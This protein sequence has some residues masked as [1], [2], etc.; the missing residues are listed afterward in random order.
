MPRVARRKV[1]LRS[2]MEPKSNPN[3][4]PILV[5]SSQAPVIPTTGATEGKHAPEPKHPNRAHG[6]RRSGG[7]D[8]LIAESLEMEAEQAR[9]N[10]NI[11]KS[12]REQIQE[13]YERMQGIESESANKKQVAQEDNTEEET[14]NETLDT[15]G[16]ELSQEETEEVVPDESSKGEELQP[17]E[18]N[19][20]YQ[21]YLKSEQRIKDTQ[22]RM[23]EATTESANY[24][25]LV[26]EI[27]TKTDLGKL[28]NPELS[29]KTETKS[30][31][32]PPPSVELMINDNEKF[33]D[34]AV[35]H[36]A[37]NP[38]LAKALVEKVIP[39]VGPKISQQ[40]AAEQLERKFKEDYKNI[41]GG[42][43][44]YIPNMNNLMLLEQKSNPHAT[45]WDLYE[46]TKP[47]F[48][49][50]VGF[51]PRPKPER[52]TV[53]LE[54]PSKRTEVEPSK[55]DTL[56]QQIVMGDAKYEKES[57]RD[58]MKFRRKMLNDKTMGY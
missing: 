18:N 32:I 56:D 10:P 34:Q 28:L 22:N 7:K 15:S 6:P 50:K 21:E 33:W 36:I 38:K 54:S 4:E 53:P 9:N 44:F 12:Q 45:M 55:T 2:E 26:D 40:T 27:S 57:H 13:R 25:K 46:L 51:K 47:K 20:W 31:T 11:E 43:D 3:P 19:P 49:E 5:Q 58:Y 29:E 41:S 17:D 14:T 23:H 8:A 30:T 52:K 42:P 24:R 39:E 35:D 16:Q 1:K 48:E 37:S